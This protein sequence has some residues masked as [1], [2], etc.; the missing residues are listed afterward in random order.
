M[1]KLIFFLIPFFILL[2]ASSNFFSQSLNIIWDKCY[3]G[4]MMDKSWNCCKV[5]DDGFVLAALSQ[6]NDYDVHINRGDFDFYIVRIKNNGDTLWTRTFGGSNID[7]GGEVTFTDDSCIV[8]T[9]VSYSS[10]FDILNTWGGGDIFAIKLDINGN[11]IWKKSYGGSSMDDPYSIVSTINGGCAILGYSYSSDYYFNQCYGNSDLILLNLDQNGDT[12]WVKNYGGT[13]SDIGNEIY[14]TNDNGFIILATSSS[15][16]FDIGNNYGSSDFWLLKLDSLGNIEWERNY[17]GTDADE[18]ISVIQTN[19]GGYLMAGMTSSTDIDIHGNHGDTDFLIIKTNAIGDTIW[20]NTLGGSDYD[21]PE[22][23]IQTSD[24]NFVVAG[25][26]N[27]TDGDISNHY[28]SD[29]YWIVKLDNNGQLLWNVCLGGNYSDQCTN[30]LETYDN[31]LLA[32]GFTVSTSEW[33]D[34]QH[35]NGD[36][37]AVK[38]DFIDNKDEINKTVKLLIFPNPTDNRLF[39][40]LNGITNV[41]IIDIFGKLI[42]E[43]KE[44]ELDINM[45]PK[46]I[47]IMIVNTEKQV[48]TE[49][50]I[51]E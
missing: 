4:S 11:T 15:T 30:I 22:S 17:G 43:S 45:I 5:F 50:I 49:K 36:V 3:G 27:S 41:K 34:P 44:T 1:K 24:Y 40:K 2:I 12:I 32:S 7:L 21:R 42:F 47:Y 19:D 39:I 16:N 23:I 51:V 8:Y 26:T 37:W 33:I 6:S 10:D 20:T 48:F 46:G 13:L 38:F 18:G 31:Y 25:Y 29:D 35:G 28:N 9:G 14:Y